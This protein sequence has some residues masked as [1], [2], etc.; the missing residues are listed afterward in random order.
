MA[1]S[2]K[3]YIDITSGVGGNGAVRLRDLIGRIFTLNP[4]V[5]TGT[6]VE[7]TTLEDV[8]NFFGFSSEEY[9]RASLYFAWVSKNITRAKKI[10]F[11]RW[12]NVADAPRIYGTKGDQSLASWGAITAGT[13][14]LTIGSETNLIGPLDFTAVPSL[15]QVATIIQN[16]IASET[17]AQWSGATVTW[18]SVRK[19]FNFVGGDEVNAVITVTPGTGGSDIAGQ[20]GWDDPVNTILSNGSVAKTVTQT[21]TESADVTNNFGSFLF[22]P[23]LT[24]EQIVEAST[25]NDAQNNLYQYMVPVLTADTADYFDALKDFGGTAITLKTVTDEYPEMIPM[26]ILAATDYT[27]RNAVQNFMYQIFPLTPSVTTTAESNALDNL[28]VNYYGRT[29]TAGQFLDFYQRG[30]LT[31]LPTDAVD[32]NVYANEQWLKD[33]AGAELMSLLL[34]LSRLPANA[35]GRSQTLAILQGVCDRA[36]FNGTISVGKPLNNVQKLYITELTGDDLAWH[37]VQGIGYWLDAVLQSYVTEDG[38]TEWKIVYS[39]VYSKDDAIRKVE[40]SHIL[41]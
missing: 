13:F 35:Q 24:I 23:A 21:L 11:A 8:G 27:K 15:T 1:I 41:I 32:Q 4:L 9:R 37:Q 39:L 31:G 17:G 22:M 7:F 20:L 3:K 29:Q 33:A 10:S 25:W 28:R 2:F 40:G 34:S 18:D 36:L 19:S 38:R 12:V 26:I 6:V 30:I 14:T 5:P 16:A